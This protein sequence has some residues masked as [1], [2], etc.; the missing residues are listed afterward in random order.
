MSEEEQMRQELQKLIDVQCILTGTGSIDCHVFVFR[1]YD[2]MR[3]NRE[4]MTELTL[5]TIKVNGHLQTRQT[6]VLTTKFD[7]IVED[8]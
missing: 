6:A 4:S 8:Q 5:A 3:V 1:L 2:A 7:N